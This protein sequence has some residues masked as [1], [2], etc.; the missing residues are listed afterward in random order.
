MNKKG[1]TLIELLVVIVILAIIAIITVP[2]ALSLISE[3]QERSDRQSVVSVKRAVE[4]YCI[5]YKPDAYYD[6]LASLVPN[7]EQINSKLSKPVYAVSDI[8]VD[9]ACN[10][11]NGFVELREDGGYFSLVTGLRV[12]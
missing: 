3:S 6:L 4:L 11:T 2:N 1:F 7:L 12:D 10:V 8:E 5:D 9:I